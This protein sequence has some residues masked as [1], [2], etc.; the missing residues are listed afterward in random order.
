[1]TIDFT[2]T[3]SVR[4]L[5]ITV[6]VNLKIRA[7]LLALPDVPRFHSDSSLRKVEVSKARYFWTSK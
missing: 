7:N 1:M 4:K 6:K 5:A 3:I 2:I